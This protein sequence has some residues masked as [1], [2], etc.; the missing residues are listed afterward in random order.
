MAMFDSRVFRDG[1]EWWAVQVHGGSGFG[2]G[3]AK[4]DIQSETIV[5]TC[6]NDQ[7]RKSRLSSI[8]AGTLNRIAHEALVDLLRRS[9]DWSVRLDID[10][11]NAPDPE[12]LA[13]HPSFTDTEGLRWVVRQVVVKRVTRGGI[14]E[15]PAVEAIC[16][17][18]SALRDEVLLENNATYQEALKWATFDINEELADLVKSKHAVVPT[19]YGSDDDDVVVPAG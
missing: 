13:R 5:F 6:L 19:R 14:V 3:P 12:E 11:A 7:E 8:A 16:L 10:P 17:D 15:H 9:K 2:C 4:P 1:E 18:D